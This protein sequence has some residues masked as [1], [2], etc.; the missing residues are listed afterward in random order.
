[1]TF[2]AW[3]IVAAIALSGGIAPATSAAPTRAADAS[4]AKK[5][6]LPFEP[7]IDVP[8]RYA[9]EMQSGNKLS[10]LLMS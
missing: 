9:F 4:I 2:R 3:C 1:M 8:L 6:T 5:I 7:P 10:G